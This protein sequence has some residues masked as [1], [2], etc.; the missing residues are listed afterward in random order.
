MTIF[1][2]A[3]FEIGNEIIYSLANPSLQVVQW[4]VLEMK[5]LVIRNQSV[6]LISGAVDEIAEPVPICMQ[7]AGNVQ[8]APTLKTEGPLWHPWMKHV[9][10]QSKCY[11][12]FLQWE[13][14]QRIEPRRKK[15]KKQLHLLEAFEENGIKR[16]F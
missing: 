3:C 2:P 6:C 7:F 13:T 8:R 9:F 15:E 11:A 10:N 16:S 4:K 14:W 12:N 5:Y 1:I